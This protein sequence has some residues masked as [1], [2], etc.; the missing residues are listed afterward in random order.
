MSF[1]RRVSQSASVRIFGIKFSLYRL[2]DYL[3][4]VVILSENPASVMQKK[5]AGAKISF[6]HP[7]SNYFI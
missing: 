7:L 6:S 4:Y 2:N 5:A 3:K 1:R